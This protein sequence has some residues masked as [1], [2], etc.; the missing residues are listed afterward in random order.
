LNEL[1][2]ELRTKRYEP[3]PVRRVYIPKPDG[4]QRPLGIPTI[5][6]RVV[7]TAVLL[8]VEPIFGASRT[9]SGQQGQVEDFHAQRY[10]NTHWR[11]VLGE[12]ISE[13]VALGS[14]WPIY[15]S[16]V[17]AATLDYQVWTDVFRGAGRL[18]ES[19][20][21]YSAVYRACAKHFP[22][23][24][25][26]GWWAYTHSIGLIAD[27]GIGN[28]IYQLGW[29][30]GTHQGHSLYN[31]VGLLGAVGKHGINIPNKEEGRTWVPQSTAKIKRIRRDDNE[32]GTGLVTLEVFGPDDTNAD[33]PPEERTDEELQSGN[34]QYL[35]G[36]RIGHLVQVRDGLART[37]TAAAFAQFRADYPPDST[38]PYNGNRCTKFAVTDVGHMSGD[39]FE[40]GPDD[41]GI[42]TACQY[43]DTLRDDEQDWMTCGVSVFNRGL[44]LDTTTGWNT[45]LFNVLQ[46]RTMFLASR[47]PISCWHGAEDSD[48]FSTQQRQYRIEVY[49]HAWLHGETHRHFYNT[50][51]AN[52]EYP[53]NPFLEGPTRAESELHTWEA[54]EEMTHLADYEEVKPLSVNYTKP[55][56]QTSD[57][58]VSGATILNDK[59]LFRVTLKDL[60]LVVRVASPPPSEG[61]QY[62]R[63][64][65]KLIG[66]IGGGADYEDFRTLTGRILRV[67]GQHRRTGRQSK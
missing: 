49:F 62:D 36:L 35:N 44:S 5:R 14:E 57:F 9:S 61:Y 18:M 8:I 58:V 42:Y 13:Q 38:A 25:A 59:R 66:P 52:S 10:F 22:E 46:L 63:I 54:M 20:M 23:V 26:A 12:T 30:L 56:I 21:L 31:A 16:D 4:K 41:D 2:E 45:F 32:D 6:D 50:S 28:P 40:S 17:T 37:D 3:Q 51:T 1:A 27:T 48:Y 19:K 55:T 47:F 67:P 7:Q 39:T 29:I 60:Q 64:H 24:T 15:N 53:L 34:D 33:A 43:I 65:S 11:P